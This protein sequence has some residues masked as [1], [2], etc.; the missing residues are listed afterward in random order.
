MAIGHS[1][2][3][4]VKTTRSARN[5]PSAIRGSGSALPHPYATATLVVVTGSG[6]LMT[7]VQ[8]PGCWSPAPPAPTIASANQDGA[9]TAHAGSVVLPTMIV[10]M[11]RSAA[12]GTHSSALS[13]GLKLL[14]RP[15]AD[16]TRSATVRI[17][18][19]RRVSVAPIAPAVTASSSCRGKTPG[20]A[21]LVSPTDASRTNFWP[22]STTLA[23]LSCCVPSRRIA[24]GSTIDVRILINVDA[25]DRRTC[26]SP[27]ARE[28]PTD[29]LG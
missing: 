1:V 3:R 13:L 17:A 15:S 22:N 19:H 24:E 20:G 14:A 11:A 26:R 7:L 2:G 12:M 28:H 8:G 18:C 16:P 5:H 27:I 29:E 23:N 4:S 9:E 21:Q 6:A 10:P 25:L